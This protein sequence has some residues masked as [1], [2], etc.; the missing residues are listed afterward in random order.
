MPSGSLFISFFYEMHWKADQRVCWSTSN[1][2]F[3]NWF[4]FTWVLFQE[5]RTMVFFWRQ[6]YL[7]DLDDY[8][9]LHASYTISFRRSPTGQGSQCRPSHQQQQMFPANDSFRAVSQHCLRHFLSW[10]PALSS[11]S[12]LLLITLFALLM[13]LHFWK[14]DRI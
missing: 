10:C 4:H 7:G 11:S 9:W 8:S 6:P 1:M 14:S 2:F 3:S 12:E 13:T 5:K